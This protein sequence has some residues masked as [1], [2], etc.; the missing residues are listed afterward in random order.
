MWDMNPNREVGTFVSGSVVPAG[1]GEWL[2]PLDGSL[3]YSDW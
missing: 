3:Y 1:V 2:I